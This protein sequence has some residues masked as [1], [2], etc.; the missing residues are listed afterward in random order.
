MNIVN[1][2]SIKKGF[3]LNL[4][5][6]ETMVISKKNS[7][8]CNVILNGSKLRQVDTFKYLG[9]WITSDGR[10]STEIKARI[11]QAKSAFQKMK[12]ILSNRNILFHTRLSIL[13]CYIEPILMYGCASWTID[14]QSENKILAAEMWFLRRMLRVS[15]KE[16]KT[17]DQV[18][19]EA[20]TYIKFQ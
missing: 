18:L 5:K 9:A 15:Y 16:H 17:N 13:E 14:R 6:T 8:E 20:N 1:T 11:A 12:T 7:K 2:Q 4:D 19:C 3:S 10:Y